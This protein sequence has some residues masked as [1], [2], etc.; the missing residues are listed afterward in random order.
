MYILLAFLFLFK[1]LTGVKKGLL[2]FAFLTLLIMN[3]FY[4]E[5]LKVYGYI[6]SGERLM[7]LA[8]YFV[9]G[10]LLSALQI[11]KISYKKV[12]LIL[13]VIAMII[14]FSFNIYSKISYIIFP[15][16]VVLFAINPLPYISVIGN[17]IGDLS[18]GIYIY[19][20]PVQQTLIHFFPLNHLEL[21]LYGFLI[22]IVFAYFSWHFVEEKAL[23]LKSL[24]SLNQS[25]IDKG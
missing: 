19:A 18:Y 23:K 17:K 8:I 16:L 14:A 25:K 10:A 13:M 5:E 2:V 22:S 20:F 3:E 4:F 9:A 21:M 11:D 6:L 12:I 7:D 24:L 1:N 15:L